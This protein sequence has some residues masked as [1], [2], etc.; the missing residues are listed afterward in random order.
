MKQLRVIQTFVSRFLILIVNF[1]LVIFS[2]NMWGSEGKGVISIVIANVAMVS[3]FSSVFSGSSTSYFARKF[4][5]EQVMSYSYLWSLFTGISIPL[6]LNI[7]QEGY[8]VYLMFISVFSSVLT[9]NISLFIGTQDI[10]RYNLYTVLQQLLHVIFLMVLIFIADFRDVSVYFLAQIFCL[11]ILSAVSTLQLF[12]KCRIRNFILTKKV[13]RDMLEYGWK[14]QLSAF[15]QFLNYRLSFYFL[16]HYQGLSAVGIFS[17]GITFSEAIWT[18]TRSIAVVLYSDV[19]N[20]PS[21]EDSIQKTKASLKVAF[22]VMVIFFLGI[23]LIPSQVY[24]LIFGREFGETRFIM[25]LLTPGIFAIAVSDMIGYY[26]SAVRELRI[27]NIKSFVGLVITIVL[28]LIIIPV[29][30]ILGACVVTV[31]SYVVS[32]SILFWRFY[33]TT[34]F[35]LKDYLITP[36]EMKI[37]FK[38]LTGKQH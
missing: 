18:I 38:T 17:I 1:G 25:L 12:K 3:F 14:T 5:V 2:T 20:S 9:T 8:L 22:S 10:K 15:V 32:A 13:F 33:T 30:G 4:Q 7:F 31:S 28:S 24:I 16:E 29:W 34:N 19:V 21:H 35:S 6:I 37:L 26:F 36:A 11:L 23:L 27:L